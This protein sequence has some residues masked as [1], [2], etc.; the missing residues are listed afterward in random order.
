MIFSFIDN[1]DS[2]HLNKVPSHTYQA[3]KHEL[4]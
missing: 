1:E 3:G 2:T 4:K